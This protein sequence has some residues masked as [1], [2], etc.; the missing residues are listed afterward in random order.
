MSN[1]TVICPSNAEGQISGVRYVE[2]GAR[3]VK[4]TLLT[5]RWKF[6][7]KHLPTNLPSKYRDLAELVQ[8]A[9]REHGTEII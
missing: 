3:I 8:K 6:A 9:A 4:C 5:S 7:R 1:K 2:I